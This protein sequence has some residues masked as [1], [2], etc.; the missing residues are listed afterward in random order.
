M[1]YVEPINSRRERYINSLTTKS[2]KTFFR[3]YHKYAEFGLSIGMLSS[4]ACAFKYPS[5]RNIDKT[6]TDITTE[7]LNQ[8]IS[9]TIGTSYTIKTVY[10]RDYLYKLV[11]LLQT[12]TEEFNTLF[13]QNIFSK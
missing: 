12:I 3:L 10:L 13:G 6:Y 9:D 2:Q 1:Q 11:D 5:S 4:R 8:I 7:M